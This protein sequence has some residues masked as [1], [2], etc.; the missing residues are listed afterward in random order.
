MQTSEGSHRQFRPCPH[1]ACVDRR[2]QR[3]HRNPVLLANYESQSSFCRQMYCAVR[4][5]SCLK[6]SVHGD[7]D[8]GANLRDNLAHSVL[9]NEQKPIVQKTAMIAAPANLK[10]ISLNY[11]H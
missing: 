8:K 7:S 3:F 2:D 5:Q 11:L 6:S 1:Q 10:V 9:Q 4:E